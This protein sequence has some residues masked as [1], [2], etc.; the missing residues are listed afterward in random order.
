MDLRRRLLLSNLSLLVIPPTATALLAALVFGALNLFP[1]AGVGFADFEKAFRLRT[2]LFSAA[3]TVWRESPDSVATEEFGKYITARLEGLTAEVLVEKSGVVLYATDGLR[4]SDVAARDGAESGSG[5]APALATRTVSI[6]G[7]PYVL[8]AQRITFSDGATGTVYLLAAT[9]RRIETAEV[10]VVSVPVTFVLF[11]LITVLAY[12]VRTSRTVSGPLVRLNETVAA[13]SEGQLAREVVEQGDEEIRQVQRSLEKLRLKLQE[14]VA[15]RGR[16]DESRRLL[17]SSI[18]HDLKTPI[19]SI[20]GY[21]EGLRDGVADTPEKRLRY[22]ETL[23]AKTLQVDRMIDDLVFFSKLELDQ[24]PFDFQD[25]DAAAYFAERVEENREGYA[26]DGMAF[27]FEDRLPA[28]AAVRIDRERMKRVFQNLFENARKYRRGVTGRISV[29]LREA[30]GRVLVEVRDEGVGIPKDSLPY[31]FDRFYRA[32]ASRGKADGSGL[33]L[34]IAKQIVDGH[35]GE[36][37]VRSTED[38]G[39]TFVVSLP[40]APAGGTR[41]EEA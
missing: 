1:G 31:I 14:S 8:Q 39:T 9:D 28:G 2:E 17:V 7:V 29:V 20:L 16:I 23:R 27:V 11:C 41:T 19:T 25:V 21:V 5:Q 34:A 6:G 36:I 3:A 26:R 32:D 4:L 12:S 33:G 37:W 30:P 18:S 22:L 15:Q 10:L 38:E 24:V 40:V 13:L 35:Q